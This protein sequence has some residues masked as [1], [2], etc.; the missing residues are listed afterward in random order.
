MRKDYKVYCV[1]EVYSNSHDRLYNIYATEELAYGA[2]TQLKLPDNWS[3]YY[4]DEMYVL[5]SCE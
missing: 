2:I 3:T 5:S 1:M 4:I